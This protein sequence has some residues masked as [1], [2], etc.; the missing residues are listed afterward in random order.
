MCPNCAAKQNTQREAPTQDKN[1]IISQPAPSTSRQK[2][3]ILQW[4]A[5]GIMTKYTELQDRLINSNINNFAVQESKLWKN[6][7]TPIIEGFTTLRKDQKVLNGGGLLLYI[8]NDLTFEKLQS[9]EQEGLEIQS[10]RIRTLKD[11]WIHLHNVYLPNTDTQVTRFNF[12]LI[13]ATPD[14]VIVGDF[15]G[16]SDLWDPVQPPDA[17]GNELEGWIYDRNLHILNDGSPTRTSQITGNNSNPDLSIC[18]GTWST[19]T[20]WKTVDPLGDSDHI[21]KL[22]STILY[23]SNQFCHVKPN[24]DGMELTGINFD[25]SLMSR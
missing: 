23:A 22:F 2:L 5:D 8:R 13:N 14:S 4:N 20:S 17:R 21:S 24:A 18:G 10:V 6:N 3:T 25:R 9:A 12:T 11:K 19:R 7:K 1:R 15:N 16:H